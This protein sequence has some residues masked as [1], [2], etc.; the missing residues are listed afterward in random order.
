MV[1]CTVPTEAYQSCLYLA[2]HTEPG[3]AQAKGSLLISVLTPGVMSVSFNKGRKVNYL[4]LG[5]QGMETTNSHLYSCKIRE[6]EEWQSKNKR[7][8]SQG[9]TSELCSNCAEKEDEERLTV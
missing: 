4:S 1:H 2:C 5:P 9:C 6:Q 7:L 8:A 3:Q